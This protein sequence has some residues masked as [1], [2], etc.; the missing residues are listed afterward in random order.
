MPTAA[1]PSA[2]SRSRPTTT[3]CPVTPPVDLRSRRTALRIVALVMAFALSVVGIC[4]I[5]FS[6]S[7]R[8]FK[9]GFPVA[10]WGAFLAYAVHGSAW[11]NPDRAP[12]VSGDGSPTAQRDRPTEDRQS[13]DDLRREHEVRLEEMFRREIER[14][15][16]QH[17]G[18]LHADVTGLRG[19]VAG[20]RG[21]VL[22]AVDG[23]LRMKRIETTRII[24]SDLA[25][26]QNE[27]RRLHDERVPPPLVG[28]TGGSGHSET[29]VWSADAVSSARSAP[30]VAVTDP[31]PAVPPAPKPRPPVEPEQPPAPSIDRSSLRSDFFADLPRLSSFTPPEPVSTASR[32]PAASSRAQGNRRHRVDTVGANTAARPSTAARP[33]IATRPDASATALG[34]SGPAH[35]GATDRDAYVGR[36]RQS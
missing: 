2:T 15:L 17:I 35:H 6:S 20:L 9:V 32:M 29:A 27:I 5:A 22:D 30:D 12:S 7:A 14:N 13:D 4:L 33:D 26:L 24:G 23:R 11:L 1:L 25:P 36:R 8:L 3:V 18:H 31:P 34:S 28:V 10:L 16:R 19:D 21:E